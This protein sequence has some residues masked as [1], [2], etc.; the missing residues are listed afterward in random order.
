MLIKQAATRVAAMV[1]IAAER[2]KK[3]GGGATKSGQTGAVSMTG[4][5]PLSEAMS[6]PCSSPPRGPPNLEALSGVPD[7][8]S[9]R[10]SIWGA[11][12]SVFWCPDPIRPL[13]GI[14]M[15]LHPTSILATSPQTLLKP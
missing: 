9:L 8:I 3:E 4:G 13:G 2:E 15:M 14:W 10:T 11:A 7:T 6:A 12:G 5:P 1:R